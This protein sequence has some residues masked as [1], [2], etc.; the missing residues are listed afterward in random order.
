[1]ESR[2]RLLPVDWRFGVMQVAKVERLRELEGERARLKRLV[3]ER[4]LE[5]D[6]MKEFLSITDAGW[7]WRLDIPAI[8]LYRGS[9]AFSL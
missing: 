5:I 4:D 3:A 6:A 2:A 8:H 9:H 7:H 1:M